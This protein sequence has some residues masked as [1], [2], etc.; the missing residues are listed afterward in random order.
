MIFEEEFLDFVASIIS[1]NSILRKKSILSEY[2]NSD[3]VKNCLRFL[4]DSNVKTGISKKKIQKKCNTLVNFEITNCYEIN[5]MISYLE[6]NNTGKDVDIIVVQNYLFVLE[7]EGFNKEQ[8]SIIE[9]FLTKSLKLGIDAKIV[10]DVIP[11]LIPTFDIML[12]TSYEN[13]NFKEGSHFYVTRKLNGTR[14]IY[15]KGKL[16]SRQGKEYTG[17]EHIIQC[18]ECILYADN[19]DP[20]DLVLDGELILD[21]SNR[22]YSDSEAF[23]IGTGLANSKDKD[24]SSLIYMVFD[25]LPVQCFDK[26][27]SNMPYLIRLKIR[28]RLSELVTLGMP[29]Q[30]LPVLYEGTDS[31]MIWKWL[32]YAEKNDWEGVMLNLDTPYE[33]KRTKSLIKVKKFYT[34]DLPVIGVEEGTGKNKFRLGALVCK[35]KDNIVKVGSGFKDEFRDYIWSNQ[36]DIIGKIIEVKYKEKTKNKDGGESLQ[37]PVFVR[38]RDDKTIGDISYD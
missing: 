2:S 1:T 33:F 37:F 13:A 38:I 17:L 34:M 12:G 25:V 22:K 24:K 21:N 9:E 5:A 27:E 28:Q 15:Y 26:K 14:C 11:G 30:F 20:H 35:Y 10:N 3:T 7:Q 4:L 29:V 18:I 36:N 8:I 16:Y 23:Q 19:T 32:D 31:E 6:S